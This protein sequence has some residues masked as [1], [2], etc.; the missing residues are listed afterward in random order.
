MAGYYDSL[1]TFIDQAVEDGFIRP[2]QRHIFVSAPTAKEL[3]QK[4]E[5]GPYQFSPLFRLFPEL[6]VMLIVKLND[7][8]TTSSGGRKYGL[9]MINWFFFFNF[10]M[11]LLLIKKMDIIC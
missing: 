6:S 2:S 7:N 10:V 3:V 1:L 8:I 11:I 5:V 9:V 4:L